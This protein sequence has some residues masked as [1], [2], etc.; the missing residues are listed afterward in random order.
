MQ[1]EK[2]KGIMVNCKNAEKI[3]Q[4]I[5]KN[6]FLNENYKIREENNIVYFPIKDY[7]KKDVFSYKIFLREFEKKKTNPKSYKEILCLPDEK[8][9]CL[10]SSYDVIGNIVL[11]KLPDEILQ[12]KKDIA[13]AILKIYKNIETVCLSKPVSGELRTRDIEII[14]GRK[15]TVTTHK[16]YG[17]S[18]LLDVNKTYFSPRLANERRRISKLVGSSEVVVDMFAGVAPFSIMIAKYADPRIVFSIDKNKDAVFYARENVKKN[19][20]LDKVE[21]FFDDAKNAAKILKTRNMQAD[22][23]IMNLPFSSYLFFPYVFKL[24][25]E[26]C[27][28]HYYDIL[29]E[30]EIENRTVDLKN[31]AEEKSFFL[32]N[33]VVNKIKTYAPREFYI[34]IDITA[35]KKK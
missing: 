14:A 34:G 9:K 1:K 21:V 2:T 16:E 30:N 33:I 31:I 3:L 18:F 19:K 32:S 4:K 15:S 35:K 7:L 12:Y 6:N 27:Y 22:R 8:L 24:F 20:V 28:I 11:I 25:T 13:K 10:P 5:K 17:L 29:K 26:R 23:V